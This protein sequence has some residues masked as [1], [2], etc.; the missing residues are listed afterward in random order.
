MNKIK[1]YLYKWCP[2]DLKVTPVNFIY[3]DVYKALIKDPNSR[4]QI[5]DDVLDHN[6]IKGVS[7]QVI[8]RVVNAV[9]KEDQVLEIIFYV[10]LKLINMAPFLTV[11]HNNLDRIFGVA[12]IG[13]KAYTGNSSSFFEESLFKSFVT[14]AA[15]REIG[16]N[17]F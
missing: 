1:M 17:D 3:Q 4:K 12:D 9:W 11:I 13:I 7:G 10:S 8:G 14:Y 2:I 15:N 16:L 6:E 5:L